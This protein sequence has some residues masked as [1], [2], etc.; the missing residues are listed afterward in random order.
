[1]ILSKSM[2][3]LLAM[4]KNNK[5]QI[6][7]LFGAVFVL[8]LLCSSDL[9]SDSVEKT[10]E[11]AKEVYALEDELE[12][13]L[14]EFLETVEGV[15]KTEVC[16]MFDLLAETS[17]AVNEEADSNEQSSVYVIIENADGS[18]GGLPICVRA[19][20]IRGVAVSCEGGAS[21]KVK[22]EVTA[23]LTA[24]LGISANRV[25]VSPYTEKNK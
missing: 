6:C 9:F 21:A 7:I 4:C 24:S 2:D 20:Q 19:P 14:E 13:K 17:Y 10:N 25:H 8:L 5:K 3:A 16:I 22:N 12:R 1:M 11:T 18:E 23:L 15:G